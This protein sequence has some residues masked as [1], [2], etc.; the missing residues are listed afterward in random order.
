YVDAVMRSWLRAV[1]CVCRSLGWRGE[2][3]IRTLSLSPVVQ[4]DRSRTG[5]TDDR[6]GVH[7]DRHRDLSLRTYPEISA[8]ARLA[9]GRCQS[10]LSLFSKLPGLS[11]R[12]RRGTYLRPLVR[13]RADEYRRED[14][15]RR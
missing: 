6:P 1:P 5:F 10:R 8:F 11:H 2:R 15:L 3:R 7:G 14:P 4:V 9:A 13:I 12:S